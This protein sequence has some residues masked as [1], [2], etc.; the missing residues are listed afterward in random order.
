MLGSSRPRE[1]EPEYEA[2]RRLG[3]EIVRRGAGVICGGYG[4]VMEAA[5]RGASEAGGEAVGVLLA[6][7]GDPN[8]WVTRRIVASDLPERLRILRDEPEAWI[9][10][11][12]G[13]GT[14]LE[15]VFIAESIVKGTAPARPL[16]L[17]GA[18]WEGTLATALSEAAGPGSRALE[19]SIRRASG[20]AEAVALVRG[21]S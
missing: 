17:L 5:C 4:G 1:G 21:S 10:L 15:L 13:L 14:M 11:P 9:V 20:A 12:R 18:F 19:A 16:V 6:G 7:G 8:R 3:G 2:A